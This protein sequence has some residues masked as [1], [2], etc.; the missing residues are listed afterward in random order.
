V[1]KGL[2]IIKTGQ[3][4]VASAR[5]AERKFRGNYDLNQKLGERKKVTDKQHPLFYD[6][7]PEN[8]LLNVS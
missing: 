4:K 5:I 2:Y 7:D 8:S 6:Y 3:C 1:P